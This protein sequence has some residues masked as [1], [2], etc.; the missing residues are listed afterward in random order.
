[1]EGADPRSHA[2]RTALTAAGP[3]VVRAK[4]RF[5]TAEPAWNTRGSASKRLTR[6]DRTQKRLGRGEPS[7]FARRTAVPAEN[8]DPE[9]ARPGPRR[10]ALPARRNRRARVDTRHLGAK[11]RSSAGN[12]PCPRARTALQHSHR[13]MCPR[14]ETPRSSGW[15][16]DHALNRLLRDEPLLFARRTVPPAR[17]PRAKTTSFRPRQ[18]RQD[19]TPSRP[20]PRRRRGSAHEA[21]SF[22]GETLW[23]ACPDRLAAGRTARARNRPAR[24]RDPMIGALVARCWC[25]IAFARSLL[26]PPGCHGATRPFSVATSLPW[27]FR[28]R[29]SSLGQQR[30]AITF[31]YCRTRGCCRPCRALRARPGGRPA[32]VGK[33]PGMLSGAPR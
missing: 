14:A 8:A 10:P 23:I 28:E 22:S 30:I 21:P 9:S 17:K 12:P 7:V 6:P 33:M 16:R 19:R 31:G 27:H 32:V 11:S 5:D 25:R 26:E 3:F 24:V 2:P 20:V 1:M 29:P 18:E 4:N 13:P 15:R